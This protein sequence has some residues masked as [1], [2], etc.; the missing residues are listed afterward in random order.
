MDTGIPEPRSIPTGAYLFQWGGKKQDKEK[1]S[2]KLR[3][4]SAIHVRK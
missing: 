3:S 4:M 1:L 2:L